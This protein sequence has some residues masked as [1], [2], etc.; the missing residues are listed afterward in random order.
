MIFD[1][2]SILKYHLDMNNAYLTTI[3]ISTLS[4]YMGFVSSCYARSELTDESFEIWK[5]SYANRAAKKGLNK[6]FVL[7]LLNTVKLDKDVIYKDQNQIV[8]NTKKDFQVFIKN[9]LRENP[10]RIALGKKHLAENYDLLNEIEKKY[11]VEKEVIVSLWGVETFYG[12]IT[13][14]YDLIQSLAS[15]AFEGRR[16]K[17]FETQL[18]AAIRLIKQGHVKREDLKGSWAGATGQC[19]FM[20]SNIKLYARDH[21]G[22]GKKDIWNTKADIFASIAYFL[23]KMGWQKGKSIGTLVLNTK[24]KDLSPHK[25]RSKLE[26]NQLG[27][28]HLDG[29]QIKDARWSKRKIASIPLNN[30]PYILKGSNYLPLIRWNNSSLFAAFNV[31]MVD[32]LRKN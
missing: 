15:L 14:D 30:S 6:R 27:F 8:F 29:S 20:P 11:Q 5:I 26:Y 1:F 10:T 18:N 3:L 22:D 16:R 21:N 2:M 25:Y 17:F 12:K 13:G 4:F 31:L 19:Q 28:R 23:K 24:D 32:G 9:W 7:S